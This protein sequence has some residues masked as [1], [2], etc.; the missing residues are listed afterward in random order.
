MEFTLQRRPTLHRTTFGTLSVD[1]QY[2]SHTLEDVIREVS[3]QPV[4]VWKVAG[5]TAI[6]A[7]RYRLTLETSPRF[8]PHTLTIHAVPGFSGVRIHAGNDDADTHGCVLVGMRLVP[9][10]TG[11]GGDIY[12][13]R[14]A[15]AALKHVVSSALTAGEC[16]LTIL[17]PEQPHV[18]IS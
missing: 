18:G 9:D 3:G 16:W 4:A 15:L 8:G 12:D 1:G 13:S 14:K 17:N 2:L 6:P 11:D 7:G 10:P 5:E